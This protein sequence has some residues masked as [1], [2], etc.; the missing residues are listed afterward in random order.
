MPH[1]AVSPHASSISPSLL[2][3]LAVTHAQNALP[4]SESLKLSLKYC[5][6]D[7]GDS[8]LAGFPI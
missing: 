3:P 7:L 8:S 4:A 5:C 6:K 1:I 2:P